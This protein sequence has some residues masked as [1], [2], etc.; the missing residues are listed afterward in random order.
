MTSRQPKLPFP[1]GTVRVEV[2]KRS[3]WLYGKG[4]KAALDATQS[5]RMRCPVFKTFT[6]P[7]D[8]LT[9][10]VAYLEHSRRRRHVE[11]VEVDR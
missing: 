2:G 6:M 7:I 8:M 1:V 10:V 4:V 3:A 5:P 9:D 11:L